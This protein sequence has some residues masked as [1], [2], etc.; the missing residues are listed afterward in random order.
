MTGAPQGP[1]P[2]PPTPA[3]ARFGPL[4]L[5]FSAGLIWFE[6]FIPGRDA[7]ARELGEDFVIRLVVGLLCVFM[8]LAM[9]ERSQLGLAFRQV[10]GAF[11]QFHRQGRD[12]SAGLDPKAR[13]DAMTILLSALSGD[14]RTTAE[15]ALNHLRRLSGQDFG[16]DAERWR[17]WIDANV[18]GA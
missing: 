14:N 18:P 3:V 10:L 7:L 12:P 1:E 4:L 6:R 15:N 2:Q 9:V 5:L 8:A 17:A 11:Q 16:Y 13:R